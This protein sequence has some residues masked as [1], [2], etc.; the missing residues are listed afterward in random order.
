MATVAIKKEGKFGGVSQPDFQTHTAA[1]VGG[2]GIGVWVSEPQTGVRGHHPTHLL[3][4][5]AP[6]P[7]WLGS[8]PEQ[9]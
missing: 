9:H 3:Q 7:P 2:C 8:L 5:A 6:K 1:A 4:E